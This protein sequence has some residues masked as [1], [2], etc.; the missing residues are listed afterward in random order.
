MFR[1]AIA[2]RHRVAG[3]AGFEPAASGFG[4]RR[5]SQ[6]ELRACIKIRSMDLQNVVFYRDIDPPLIILFPYEQ[7]A[8]DR[9]YN[10]S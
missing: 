6:L 8:D 9:I 4:D 3:L 5:S 2:K 7:Y 10:T 1:F